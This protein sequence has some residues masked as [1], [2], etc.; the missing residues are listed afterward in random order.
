MWKSLLVLIVAVVFIAVVVPL[1]YIAM[2]KVKDPVASSVNNNAAVPVFGQNYIPEAA[3]LSDASSTNPG[4]F[5]LALESACDAEEEVMI[6]DD[7]IDHL[8]LPSNRQFIESKNYNFVWNVSG[9]W[10]NAE[11][12]PSLQGLFPV[13]IKGGKTP[14]TTLSAYMRV[15]KNASSSCTAYYNTM[16]GY[17]HDSGRFVKLNGSKLGWDN[18]LSILEKSKMTINGQSYYWYIFQDGRISYNDSGQKFVVSF[19][20]YKNGISYSINF[21]GSK[22]KNG[23][24]RKVFTTAAEYVAGLR[25]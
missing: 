2:G 22:E 12:S 7:V 3:G 1:A 15:G 13:F 4:G 11:L 16:Y 14:E 18:S 21:L 6:K 17:I 19:N 20:T 9:E 5:D 8:A 23:S 24:Y 25:I 10:Q